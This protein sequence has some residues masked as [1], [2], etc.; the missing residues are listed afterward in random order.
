MA[1]TNLVSKSLGSILQQ[2]DSGTPNHT[3]ARGCIYTNTATGYIYANIDGSTT[4]DN[5]N[6]IGQGLLYIDN[7]TTQSTFVD[8]NVWYSVRTLAWLST[9][10]NGITVS[11]ANTLTI[12]TGQDGRYFVSAAVKLKIVTA[13]QYGVGISKNASLPTAGYY[14]FDSLT[15]DSTGTTV[16]VVGYLDLVAGDTIEIGI[17]NVL[18]TNAVVIPSAQLNVKRIGS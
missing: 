13:A 17:K 15:T 10:L 12:G 7:N 1:T 16:G 6:H 2:S 5:I 8:T 4:W 3:A 18:N 14:N 9:S 11:T